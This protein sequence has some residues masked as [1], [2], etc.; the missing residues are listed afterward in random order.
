MLPGPQAR[1]FEKRHDLIQYGGVARA[2]DIGRGR[3]GE[4]DPIVGD[5]RAHAL[6]RVRQPPMLHVAFDELPA[7]GAQKMPRAFPS[8]A[9][10]ASA[11]PS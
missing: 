8:G 3:E 11:M 5:S 10:K 7:G 9:A 6:P 2:G 4:P 1:A